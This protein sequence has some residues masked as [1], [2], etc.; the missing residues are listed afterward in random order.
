MRSSESD[1]STAKNVAVTVTQA[2]HVKKIKKAPRGTVN[3]Y[4]T[5]ELKV[6]DDEVKFK[7][8]LNRTKEKKFDQNS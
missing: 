4:F 6:T 1:L 5:K 2:C 7:E 8:I 3:V